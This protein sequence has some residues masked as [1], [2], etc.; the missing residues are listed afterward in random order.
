MIMRRPGGGPTAFVSQDS[1]AWGGVVVFSKE[2]LSEKYGESISVQYI[3]NRNPLSTDMAHS[4]IIFQRQDKARELLM[5]NVSFYFLLEN[6]NTTV[7]GQLVEVNSKKI[8]PGY[9]LFISL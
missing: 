5:R 6:K 8:E 7:A 2:E 1:I 4:Q 9:N 3:L